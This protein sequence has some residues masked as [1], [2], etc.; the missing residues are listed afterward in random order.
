MATNTKT[1]ETWVQKARI[2]IGDTSSSIVVSES[3]EGR[4]GLRRFVKTETYDGPA[5]GG[6][7]T[8]P[9]EGRQAL[10]DALTKVG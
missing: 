6:G 2:Q 7:L 3:S 10:I 9:A 8:V 1:K 5:K 4:V